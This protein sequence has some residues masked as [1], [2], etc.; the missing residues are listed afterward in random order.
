MN[1]QKI[2]LII[3]LSISLSMLGVTTIQAQTIQDSYMC[4]GYGVTDL[5]PRGV[6]N[7]IFTYTEQIGFWVQIQNPADV[8]YRMIWTDPNGNQFRNSAVEVIEKS[9]TDWGIVFDS[10]KIA[11]TTAK[12]KLGVWTVSLYVD[13]EVMAE[14]EFQIIDYDALIET[15][16][17]FSDQLDD[18]IDEKDTILAQKAAVEASLAALQADYAALEA[19][20]GTTSDYEELQ[21]NYNDLNDDYEA[22]KA[23]QGTTKTMMYASI[24]VA[25]IA[26]VVAVYFGVMKK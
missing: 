18:L 26:V 12:N 25:L 24:V 9:G 16:S 20:V 23:S 6:G 21:D 19:S 1:K 13:G 11:E 4:Y 8:S 17:D 3:L 14:G 2:G 5:Q 10:I 7:T 22:L 15:F